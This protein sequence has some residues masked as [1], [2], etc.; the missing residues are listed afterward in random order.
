LLVGSYAQAW[1]LKA[2]RKATVS[3]TVKAFRDY[4]PDLVPLPHP[5]WRNNAWI[6]K[7]PWFAEELLP[8]LRKRVSR[9]LK[10]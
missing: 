5:S 7:N 10:A 9:I 8:Q 6:T 1:H 3:D 4:G 2:R